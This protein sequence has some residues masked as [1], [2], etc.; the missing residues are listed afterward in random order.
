MLVLWLQTGLS[1]VLWPVWPDRAQQIYMPGPVLW[2]QCDQCAGTMVASVTSD[3]VYCWS[4]ATS[5]NL[6]CLDPTR[7]IREQ[8]SGAAAAEQSGGG[9]CVPVTP[10]C[11]WCWT[12]HP[13]SPLPPHLTT[14]HKPVTLLVCPH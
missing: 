2:C 14:T 5:F 7:E 13:T 12:P 3:Q 4:R 10:T 6:L 11:E 8:S 1:L 9:W